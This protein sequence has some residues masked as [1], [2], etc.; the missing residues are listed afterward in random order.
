MTGDEIGT[1][2]LPKADLDLAGWSA[3]SVLNAGG[4]R[5]SCRYYPYADL[6]ATARLTDNGTTLTVKVSDGFA[7]AQQEVLTGLLVHLISRLL[8][9]RSISPVAAELVE[10][11]RE[12]SKRAST[13]EFG[14][15]LH[16]QRHRS[17]PPEPQGFAYNLE[18]VCL[19]VLADYSGVFGAMSAP[20][21]TWSQGNGSR[22]VLAYH[23]RS[24]KRIVVSRKL[25]SPRVPEL[26][27]QRIVF[28]E[29]LHAKH[30]VK[31][32]CGP[33]MQARAHTSEFFRDESAF[34][35]L[36]EADKWLSRNRI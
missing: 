29:L 9:R 27:I 1:N 17:K 11:Y 10:K 6:K 32:E 24:L 19:R 22:R 36:A 25:D 8:R 13:A 3:L 18:E 23:D 35:G 30:G 15:T 28:H 26:V 34:E 2:P 21:I 5:I 4:L 12:F 14:H 33:S 20:E 31:Y 7:A 16:R